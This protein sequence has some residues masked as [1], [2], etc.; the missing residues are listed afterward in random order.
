[1]ARDAQWIA[2]EKNT[3]HIE[4][5]DTGVPEGWVCQG[6]GG[7]CKAK[8]DQPLSMSDVKDIRL[9]TTR[10][11]LLELRTRSENWRGHN[12]SVTLGLAADDLL[13]L[14]SPLLDGTREP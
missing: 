9:T 3:G 2:H 8:S 12:G 11:L 1:M 5:M 14:N 4:R 6:D 7:R 13:E 10:D